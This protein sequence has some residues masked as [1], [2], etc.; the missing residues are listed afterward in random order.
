M[1]I[2]I[3]QQVTETSSSPVKDT[4]SQTQ[5]TSQ[6]ATGTEVQAAK[7][8]RGSAW[9]W[10]IVGIIDVIL[11]LRLLFHLFGARN[12]GFAELLYNIS[13]PFVAPFRGIFAAP[14]VEGTYFDTAS[15][16]A[17]IVYILIGWG[18]TKLVELTTRPTAPT[19]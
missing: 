8:E 11:A 16:A 14:A 6:A 1:P 9:V 7:S 5:T 3:D 12:V 18:V 15:F 13:S 10:Y 4:V 19:S 2:E 17:I